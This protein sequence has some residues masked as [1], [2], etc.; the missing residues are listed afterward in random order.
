M[1]LCRS[2]P[3]P[4]RSC[5][6]WVAASPCAPSAWSI[7]CC[8]VS[9]NLPPGAEPAGAAPMSAGRMRIDGIVL[10]MAD[11]PLFLR[12][13]LL[14][15]IADRRRHSASPRPAQHLLT[16]QIERL[17]NHIFRG[18]HRRCVQFIGPHRSE[19][20]GHL[21]GGI[22]LRIS[23]EALGVGIGMSRLEAHHR[24]PLIRNYR[25]HAHGGSML[26]L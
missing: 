18:L 12:L 9:R 16:Q 25:R 17:R 7:D 11:L 20:V 19:E 24:R 2:A 14:V 26:G 15:F 21:L 22:D 5:A 1:A 8:S 10:F 23:Y 6:T 13:L 3:W 4:F